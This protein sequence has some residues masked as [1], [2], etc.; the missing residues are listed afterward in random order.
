MYGYGRDT[1][2]TLGRLAE[3]GVLFADNISQ[4][5]WTKVSVPPAS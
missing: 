1:S 4:G 3:E 5:T 2:P